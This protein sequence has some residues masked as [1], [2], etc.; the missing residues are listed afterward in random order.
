MQVVLVPANEIAEELGDKRMANLVMLGALLENLDV[1][2]VETVGESLGEHIPE[3]RRNLL[4]G[5]L[6]ALK[7]GAGLAKAAA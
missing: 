4:E 6:E 7:R 2:S 5:N 3:H 1:L